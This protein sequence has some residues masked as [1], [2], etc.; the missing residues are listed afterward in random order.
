MMADTQR[1]IAGQQMEFQ[2]E[3]ADR[4]IAF[5]REQYER[6]RRDLLA[7]A[8]K[9]RQ[10][11][12]RLVKEQHVLQN[13]PLRLF[14]SQLLAPTGVAKSKDRALTPLVILLSMPAPQT[15]EGQ[16][17]DIQ[18]HVRN[19]LQ[20]FLYA[21]YNQNTSAR[22]VELLDLA[23][24]DP[25]HRG[26]S[27][28]K[29]LYGRLD[30]LSTVVLEADVVQNALPFQ[31]AWW[32]PLQEGYQYQ[33][34][35]EID[36]RELLKESARERARQWRQTR[37]DLVC[38]GLAANE[39]EADQQFGGENA[40]NLKILEQEERLKAKPGIRLRPYTIAQEDF[41]YLYRHLT[42]W[43]CLATALVADIHHFRYNDTLPQ[44]PGLLPELI[45]GTRLPAD[46]V[47]AMLVCTYAPLAEARPDRARELLTVLATLP[48][49]TVP[50]HPL[51]EQ[52]RSVAEVEAARKVS[53]EKVLSVQ[54]QLTSDIPK[55]TDSPWVLK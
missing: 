54:R 25:S 17:L 23:W 8:E 5:Q 41:D 28:I 31:F 20:Q 55:K 14:P 32:G 29:A 43:Y 18:N 21:H 15:V 35:G 30:C 33:H 50:G 46:Q 48:G 45:A 16:A 37:V 9:R 22:P 12:L 53:T 19:R 4:Q 1:G 52:L 44:L 49:Q 34:L 11:S 47:A 51:L 26:G 38:Q 24:K 7:D 36:W 40:E 39:A 6:Q 10:E 13:W 27:A 2:R 3:Q 42:A